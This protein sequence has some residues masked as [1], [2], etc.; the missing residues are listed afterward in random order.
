MTLGIYD[1]EDGTTEVPCG[2]CRATGVDDRF[3]C[4]WC[5]GTRT[6]LALGDWRLKAGTLDSAPEAPITKTV[7]VY[8]GQEKGHSKRCSVT[9]FGVE[10]RKEQAGRDAA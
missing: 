3:A 1:A 7:C 6:V 2:M 10:E 5:D 9:K 4:Q 8:C